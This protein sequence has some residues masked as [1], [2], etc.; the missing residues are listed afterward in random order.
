M[1]KRVQVVLNKDV[2]KLGEAGDLLEVA[3]GFARNYLVPQGI[4]VPAT[5]GVIK[6]FEQRKEKERQRLLEIKRQAENRKTA[7][8]TIGRFV[9]KKQVG[10]EDAIFGTVT[11]IDV[12]EAIEEATGQEVDRRGITLPEINKTGFYKAQVKLHP[13]VEAN[14]EIQ[15]SPM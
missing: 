11:N 7:L 10:E 2:N 8:E 5:P 15:V 13:E 4:A 1:A 3:P 9:I 14:I 12:A 6:Q